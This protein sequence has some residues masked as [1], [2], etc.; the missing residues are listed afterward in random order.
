[1][2]W[3]TSVCAEKVK[4]STNHQRLGGNERQLWRKI[5]NIQ[6]V[7]SQRSINIKIPFWG[8]RDKIIENYEKSAVT[9]CEKARFLK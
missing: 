8:K 7:Q 2:Q 4:K 9:E 6:T 1:M 5:C 3:R